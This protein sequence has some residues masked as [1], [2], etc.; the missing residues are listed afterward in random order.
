MDE[1]STKL[2]HR[3]NMEDWVWDTFE[4]T[5]VMST[6][7]LACILSELEYLET[8]YRS[9]NGRNITIKLWSDKEKFD[10]LDLAF[11]LVPKVMET[12]ENYLNIPYTLPKLDMVAVPGYDAARAMENW[13]LIVQRS[14][15]IKLFILEMTTNN[16]YYI[17]IP[18]M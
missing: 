11:H 6:Y 5:P 16:V 7:L 9:I 4:T 2:E 1:L 18:I 14:V 3:E 10:Q 12:L 17:T 8:S 15:Y 13:G